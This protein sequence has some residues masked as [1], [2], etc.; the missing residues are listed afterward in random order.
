MKNRGTAILLCLFFGGFG[1]HQFYLGRVGSGFIRLFFFWTFIPGIIAFF[2]FFGLCFMGDDKFSSKY[3][4][5][6]VAIT[7]QSI[8]A[9]SA[10]SL[11][12][13]ASLYEKNLITKDEFE[14]KKK[15]LLDKIG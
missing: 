6:F 12:K 9:G 5:E 1:A 3:N 11:S 10:D 8:S 2:E 7:S 4:S 13:L 14:E 15:A